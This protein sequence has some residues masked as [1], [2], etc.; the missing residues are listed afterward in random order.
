MDYQHIMSLN[1]N[2]AQQLTLY[3]YAFTPASIDVNV[4]RGVLEWN[5]VPDSHSTI[6]VRPMGYLDAQE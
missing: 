1:H 6:R 3:K 5:K 2:P 4:E